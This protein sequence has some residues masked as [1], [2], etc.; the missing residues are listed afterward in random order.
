ME[1][2]KGLHAAKQLLELGR[3]RLLK[4]EGEKA[5]K[6]LLLVLVMPDQVC[7]YVV[8]QCVRVVHR[9]LYLFITCLFTS[10]HSVWDPRTIIM[11]NFNVVVTNH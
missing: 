3:S 11:Q 7:F 4:E 2:Q 9:S 8:L 10:L 6:D 1:R 5:A